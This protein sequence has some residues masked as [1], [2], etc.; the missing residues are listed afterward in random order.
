MRTRHFGV[1]LTLLA[2]SWAAV[3]IPAQTPGT[4]TPVIRAQSQLVQLT[5][6][7]RD[8]SGHAV[9]GLPEGAFDVTEDGKPV[10]IVTFHEITGPS[11]ALAT[12]AAS[13]SAAPGA[14]T[15]AIAVAPANVTIILLDRLNTKWLGLARTREALK[16]FFAKVQPED[17]IAVYAL[18]DTALWVLQDF[19][20]DTSALLKA[21]N[22]IA[23][24][25]SSRGATLQQDDTGDGYAALM[26]RLVATTSLVAL[27]TIAQHVA[28]IPGRKNLVWV[29]SG[30]PLPLDAPIVLSGKDRVAAVEEAARALNTSQISLYG[31]DPRGLVTGCHMTATKDVCTDTFASL[32]NQDVAN[33]LA[34]ETGGRVFINDND[35]AGA[36]R[37]AIDDAEHH[38]E[39]DYYSP[40]PATDGQYHVITV[41]SHTSGL[42]LAYRRG[43]FALPASAPDG[44]RKTALEHAIGDPLDATGIPITVTPSKGSGTPPTAPGAPVALSIHAGPGGITLTGDP[45][46]AW[47]G[48][49]DL[50]IAEV[51]NTGQITIDVDTTITLKLQ[52]VQHDAFVRDGMGVSNS[53]TVRPDTARVVVVLRDTASGALGSVTLPAAA[54]RALQ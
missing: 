11:G 26:N 48:A 40:S 5:V 18:D 1:P 8:H 14:F 30:F 41:T 51:G 33:T 28:T 17:R 46:G 25:P 23:D 15:N 12:P 43:Y 16:P 49:F 31:I 35:I 36:V 39:I 20:S 27:E 42:T 52:S 13:P 54:L 50:A 7:A 4:Q 10:R 45:A 44:D 53:I 19:T 22:G 24:S 34:D 32:G 3:G 6:V 29:S 21:V 47:T 38:Y 9:A 37:A 2:A